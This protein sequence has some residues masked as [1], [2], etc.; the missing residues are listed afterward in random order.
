MSAYI[1]EDATINRIVSFLALN[2]D[3]DWYRRLIKDNTG[4]DLVTPEG[5]RNL[6]NA[7]FN[8]NCKA[9]DERYGEG[10]AKEFRDLDFKYRREIPDRM[11]AY[12][13]LKCW[14]Y[15]CTE[16]SVPDESLLYSTMNQIKGEIADDIVSSLPAYQAAK[17]E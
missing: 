6:A 2:R 16:G 15:Q 7:M 12:T 10:Q 3:G 5:Q 4:C 1:V 13:S 8:L 17:W 14:L 9:I 11:K